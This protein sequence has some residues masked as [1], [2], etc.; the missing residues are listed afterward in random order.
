MNFPKVT[1]YPEYYNY[2]IKSVPE[3]DLLTSLESTIVQAS[4]FLS[5]IEEAKGDYRYAPEKWSIKEVLLHIIDTERVMAY[6]A[7]RFARGDT[8][9]LV[10]F[11]QNLFAENAD[12]SNRTIADLLAEFKSVR[13]ASIFL[14]KYLTEEESKQIGNAS[15]FPVSVRA[16]AA[17]IIGHAVHHLNVIKEKY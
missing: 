2:I 5:N 12:V 9:E 4:T 11:D 6:R 13:Q 14:F 7:M 3:G 8:K 1:E 10:G 15:G 17:I 16:L